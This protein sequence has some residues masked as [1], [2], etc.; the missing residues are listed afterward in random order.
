MQA[1]TTK[2]TNN[3]FTLSS[4]TDSDAISPVLRKPLA[5]K[6]QKCTAS[7]KVTIYLLK[8]KKQKWTKQKQR[9]GAMFDALSKMAGSIRKEFSLL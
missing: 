9:A 7:L 1:I 4:S 2:M 3:D 6:F 8:S 5:N